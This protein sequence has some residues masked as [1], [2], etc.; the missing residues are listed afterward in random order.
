MGH[1][2]LV[3]HEGQAHAVRIAVRRAPRPAV[4]A[5]VV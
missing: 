4:R 3:A 5:R 2:L 1:G